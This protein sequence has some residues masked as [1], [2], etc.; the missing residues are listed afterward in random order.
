MPLKEVAVTTPVKFAAPPFVRFKVAVPAV[1]SDNCIESSFEFEELKV[2]LPLL[3]Y[4]DI[5]SKL[6]G[7]VIP[8]PTTTL[9]VV[10]I[11]SM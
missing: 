9:P 10:V 5:I 7:P 11:A 1:N 3:L 8:P 4:S 2:I 6:A